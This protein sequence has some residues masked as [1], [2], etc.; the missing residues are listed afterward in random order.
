MSPTS[1]IADLQFLGMRIDIKRKLLSR[2]ERVKSVDFHP[3]ET[4]VLASLYNGKV[5][6][7]NYETQ[8]LVK[9]F[10]VADVPVRAAKFIARKNW[11]VTGSDDSQIRVFNYNTHE[12]VASFEG[13]PDYIRCLA[14]HPTQPFVLSGSDDMTIRLWDWEK[15]WKMT[16]VFEGHTHFVM[17]MTFNPK[18]SNTFASAGLDRTI[19]VWS[20]GSPVPNFTLEGHEKGV[21][22]VD[23]YHG[24]DK[25]YIVSCA[26]DN[27]V[28][29]WDY[30][31]KNC[32]QTLDGHSNNVSFASFHPE[33]PIIISGSEDGTIKIWHSD[34]YR[35]E[36]TLNYGL[37]RAWTIAYRRGSNN[38]AFGFDEGTVV[39]KLGREEPAVSMDN[40]GKIIWAKHSEIQ[41]ANIKTGVDDNVKDGERLAVPIKD[42]GSCEIYPQTLQHSPNGRFAVVC[43]D[44]EYIIYTALSWR[45]KT[46]GNGLD[47]VW[48]SDSNIYAVRESTSRVKIFKNFKERSGLLPKLNY[49]AE[50]IHGGTLLCV[51]ASGFLTF[52]DWETGMPVRRIEAEA[53][54]VYW[55][56]TGEL[57]TIVCDES[58]Y[59]LKFDRQSYLQAVESGE[60]IGEEGVDEAIELVTEIPSSVKTALWVGD[61]FIYTDGNNRL[62]YL[63]GEETYTI[64]HFDTN[65]YLLSYS[66]RESKIYLCDR[67]VNLYAWSLSLTVIEY[68]TAILRGDLDTAAEVLP[69]IPTD[70]RNRIARFLESQDLKELA[71]NVTED[72]EHQFDLA[73]QLD[74]LDIAV[75]IA[76]KVDTEV[77]WKT[78]GDF[79][80]VAWKLG[81]AEECLERAND[82][83][84]LLLLHT[85]G[86]NATGIRK[87]ADLALAKGKNNIAFSAL[88]QLGATQEAIDLLI[89]TDRI[90]E[91]AM[92]ARTYM[93]SETSRVVKLWKQELDKNNRPKVAESLADPENYPNLFPELHAVNG[94]SPVEEEAP[95]VDD[96][97][98]TV[99]QTN[100]EEEEEQEETAQE[101]ALEDEESPVE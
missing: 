27:T 39:I 67:D 7:W 84:G 13:H 80:M 30:Q 12:K 10:E 88:L 96:F 64:T 98:D 46:F 14:V 58:F 2:S 75:D 101:D 53:K 100:E 3:T 70:Q 99:E 93:P 4:W 44:G 83:S 40:S 60:P 72:V 56:E 20:L 29:I 78:V 94:Q 68:Q 26:D 33:L 1:G 95:E 49:S 28:K 69:T 32:V 61:C 66:P 45:N 89:K 37:E 6:I 17:N 8:A 91:A 48:A 42:L 65:M 79:A 92:F 38:V 31:N 35:L 9:T 81:L 11:I 47:F 73:I 5:L 62:N 90:P 55:S 15:G 86:G 34:T 74:K 77:K 24:G 25:P 59:I 97:E 18:D 71:M 43:G 57:L 52:Y 85:S 76:R 22:Y 41:F 21:N 54:N 36:N 51:R 23:Y 82:L 19:K 16:Q 63:V 50:G 87:V